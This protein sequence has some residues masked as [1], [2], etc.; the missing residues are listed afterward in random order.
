M[1]IYNKSGLHLLTHR[2]FSYPAPNIAPHVDQPA[3]FEALSE[4]GAAK[5]RPVPG[6]ACQFHSSQFSRHPPLAG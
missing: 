3:Q 5:A 1:Y 6:L 2:V 4:H